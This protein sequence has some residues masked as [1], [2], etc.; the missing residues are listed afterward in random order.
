LLV[1]RLH[2]SCAKNNRSL[3][4]RSAAPARARWGVTCASPWEGRADRLA[5]VSTRYAFIAL[6]FVGL[7][8]C[9]DDKKERLI[10][11][12]AGEAAAPLGVTPPPDASA[13]GTPSTAPSASADSKRF[14]PKHK[15]PTGQTHFYLEGDF[16]RRKCF[17]NGDCGKKEH[18]SAIDYPFVV[19]GGVAGMSKFCEGT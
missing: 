2:R 16:C 13:A 9:D 19:D 14:D 7:F 5:G 11:K 1:D 18:C 10:N 15:C 3:R 12:T 8:G 17:T 6:A 4:R